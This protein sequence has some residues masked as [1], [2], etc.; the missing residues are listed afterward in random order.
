MGVLAF[1]NPLTKIMS[2]SPVVTRAYWEVVTRPDI[3]AFVVSSVAMGVLVAIPV[4]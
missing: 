2:D 3:F 1:K 4:P